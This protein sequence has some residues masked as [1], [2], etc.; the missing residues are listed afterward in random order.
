MNEIFKECLYTRCVVYIDDILVFGEDEAEVLMN[1]EWVLKKCEEN[2]IK[3]K[4]T[5]CEFLKQE[6]KFLGYKI[7]SG[8][9][10][11]IPDKVISWK[12]ENPASVKEAQAFLGYVNYYSR[13][14]KR[15]SEKTDGIRKAI[16]NQPFAWTDECR[17]IKE[18]LLE[19]LEKT[20]VQII[21]PAETA[22]EIELGIL[23]NSME[24]TC[25]TEEG[26]IIMR[27]SAVLSSTQ[28]NYP[29]LEKELLA[30][31]RA[32]NKFGKFLKGP[33]VVKTSCTLMP[34]LLMICCVFSLISTNDSSIATV[35]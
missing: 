4:L 32:Y 33:V 35:E 18:E 19:E 17:A 29:M 21:P 3:L 27:T 14:I 26:E 1:L 7:G 25:L 22:K 9:I 11:S 24:A 30:L 16:K 23:D 34:L 28:K 5:K 10:A 2:D 15:F 13:F 20:T 8:K 31:V 12:V 6:V